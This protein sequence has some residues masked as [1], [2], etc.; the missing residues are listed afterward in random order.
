MSQALRTKKV[1]A[2]GLGALLAP[3]LLSGAAHADPD[4]GPGDRIAPI[5]PVAPVAAVLLAQGA[6]GVFDIEDAGVHLQATG[7]TDLAMVQVTVQPH[8]S[9]GWHTHAGPSMVIVKNGAVR[10]IEPTEGEHW[11]DGHGCTDETFAAGAAFA[12]PADVHDVANDGAEPA[13][14]YITY[15]LPEGGTPALVPADPPPGC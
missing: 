13:V 14:V 6:A 2:I 12:H 11:G 9:T 5:P 4:H 3:V 1:L 15:F 10:L 7:S 8:S